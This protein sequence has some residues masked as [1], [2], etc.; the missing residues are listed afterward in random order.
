VLVS[1]LEKE[2]PE[3]YVLEKDNL[4]DTRLI[5]KLRWKFA[6]SSKHHTPPNCGE[7]TGGHRKWAAM[8]I[9]KIYSDVNGDSH[10]E[11]V[12]IALKNAGD[13]GRLSEKYPVKSII[14]RQ[15]DASYNYDWHTAPARQYI[16]LLD[17]EIEIEVSSG[18][19]R[20]FCSGDILLME[21]TTGRGHKTRVTNNQPRKSIFVTL[22]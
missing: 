22:D 1:R 7:V 18:G 17:G 13:I 2:F 3:T 9:T 15:T 16:I 21:D 20:I 14:F 10:F 8:K 6:F 5:R 19:K 4:G 12:E 11:D